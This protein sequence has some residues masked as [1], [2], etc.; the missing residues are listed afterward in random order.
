MHT[1]PPLKQSEKCIARQIIALTGFEGK[2]NR[3]DLPLVSLHGG[4]P[5]PESGTLLNR[6]AVQA[7]QELLD[8]EDYPEQISGH[9]QHCATRRHLH[10][11]PSI[12]GHYDS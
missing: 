8:G 1:L 5:V 4:V 11:A 2:S 9:G 7:T 3:F 10:A 6:A 12:G